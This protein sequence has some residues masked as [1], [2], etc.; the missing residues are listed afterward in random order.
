MYLFL[1]LEEVKL[2]IMES[3][4]TKSNVHSGETS[5]ALLYKALLLAW[6]PYTV[7][8]DV[9]TSSQ[10]ICREQSC[11]HFPW[12]CCIQICA[13]NFGPTVVTVILRLNTSVLCT[14]RLDKQ[15]PQVGNVLAQ[16]TKGARPERSQSGSF[17]QL[18]QDFRAL[19]RKTGLCNKSGMIWGSSNTK[20]SSQGFA[21][22]QQQW[23]LVVS[24][25]GTIATQ[26]VAA[27][28]GCTSVPGT[29]AIRG[30]AAQHGCTSAVFGLAILRL[31]A[32]ICRIKCFQQYDWKILTG[33]SYIE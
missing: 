8:E 19:H 31:R 23:L 2:R 18:D 20:D 21:V 13:K 33:D 32:E 4:L 30:A 27:Q 12:T 25:P 22:M 11:Q 24:V 15:V 1:K 3:V 16:R 28:H 6:I 17:R 29:I 9:L 14:G 10:C 7:W 26:S 5:V